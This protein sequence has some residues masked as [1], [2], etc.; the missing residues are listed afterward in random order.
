[1]G[2]SPS[3]PILCSQSQRCPFPATLSP[4]PLPGRHPWTSTQLEL[5]KPSMPS[6]L[7]SPFTESTVG[8]DRHNGPAKVAPLSQ[9]SLSPSSDTSS[10]LTRGVKEVHSKEVGGIGWVDRLTGWRW[11]SNKPWKDY[12]PVQQNTP[13]SDPDLKSAHLLVSGKSIWLVITNM[14]S[15]Q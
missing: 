1:M 15:I 10:A 14:I 13:L 5:D 3:T 6:P 11:T 2:Q 4:S 12:C 8:H 9:V 7:L